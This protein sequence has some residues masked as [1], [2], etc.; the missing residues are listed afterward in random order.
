M[1]NTDLWRYS[2]WTGKRGG[3]VRNVWRYSRRTGGS[4][5]RDNI[6]HGF[7]TQIVLY[8]NTLL[9]KPDTIMLMFPRK[10]MDA[11]RKL[12]SPVP[13]P[14][15]WIK[16]SW[17]A[18]S[19]MPKDKGLHFKKPDF[20]TSPIPSSSPSSPFSS[21]AWHSSGDTCGCSRSW[22]SCHRRR[23]WRAGP[24]TWPGCCCRQG[25]SRCLRRGWLPSSRPLCRVGEWSE[26]L[27]MR[28]WGFKGLISP[29]FE[30]NFF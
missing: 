18:Q 22:H 24:R 17:L 2:R 6:L 9:K 11:L 25:R 20:P 26:A 10:T 14:G 8:Y 13:V 28:G 23:S 5:I 19:K 30:H 27:N 21:S 12:K 16:R 4:E 15:H 29:V 7:V 1:G 3:G